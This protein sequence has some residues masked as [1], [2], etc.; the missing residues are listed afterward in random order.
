MNNM[1]KLSARPLL[2]MGRIEGLPTVIFQLIQ[3]HL[4]EKEYLQSMSCRKESFRSVKYET[5]K[6]SLI[7]NNHA[8]EAVRRILNSV[9]D[10]AKQI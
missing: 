2:Q 4:N 3:F 8:G 7:I 10:K 6:Y 5:V 1:S 9:K